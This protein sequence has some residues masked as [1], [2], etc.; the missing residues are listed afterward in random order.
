MTLFI[1]P[2][3]SYTTAGGLQELVRHGTAASPPSVQSPSRKRTASEAEHADNG[4]R[5]VTRLSP[6]RPKH[7]KASMAEPI[8]ARDERDEM[9]EDMEDWNMVECDGSAT[10]YSTD[11]RR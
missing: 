1:Q 5:A 6:P 3:G 4:Q 9:E 2:G 10:E 11:A 7:R 8:R